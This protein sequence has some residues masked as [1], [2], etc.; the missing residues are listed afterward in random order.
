MPGYHTFTA[1]RATAPHWPSVLSTLRT[2]DASVGMASDDPF[3]ATFKKSTEWTPTQIAQ[4]QNVIDTAP[5]NTPQVRA[6]DVV[7]KM[8]IFEKAL[9]LSI[10]DELNRRRAWDA[11][12]AAAVAAATSLADLKTR[13]ALLP[14]APDITVQAAIQAVRDKAGTL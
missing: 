7:D 1:N 3:V 14:A 11:G 9:L 12:L 8:P 5:A 6:Q 13:V 4:T 10:I 2:Q